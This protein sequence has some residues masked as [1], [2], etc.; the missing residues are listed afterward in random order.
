MSL[1]CLETSQ[2]IT[3]VQNYILWI[4]F[5]IVEIWNSHT[6]KW[7]CMVSIPK[8]ICCQTKFGV[9]NDSYFD[10]TG[11]TGGN[12][13][14]LYLGGAWLFFLASCLY[15]VP[16][17]ESIMFE[18]GCMVPAECLGRDVT[19]SHH[20]NAQYL[21]NSLRLFRSGNILK[22]EPAWTM[23][24]VA[25]LNWQFK[26][27][28]QSHNINSHIAVGPSVI[29]REW[30]ISNALGRKGFGVALRYL[31]LYTKATFYLLNL[32]K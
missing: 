29:W 27:M 26:S 16:N 9:L 12:A 25:V 30:Y 14:D 5:F 17:A 8:G 31:T 13:L 11:W 28:P 21:L 4:L 18:Q 20:H 6:A 2:E 10:W 1:L 24:V 19:H 7:G 15:K 23:L 32:L 3:A 22:H